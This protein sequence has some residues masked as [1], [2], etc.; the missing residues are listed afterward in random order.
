[1]RKLAQSFVIHKNTAHGDK[2]DIPFFDN[3]RA[4][5]DVEVRENFGTGKVSILVFLS[6]PN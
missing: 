5:L 4:H 2:W 1:M 3:L 6:T